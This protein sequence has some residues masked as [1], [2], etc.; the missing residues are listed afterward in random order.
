MIHRKLHP[1]TESGQSTVDYAGVGL[2][3][4]AIVAIVASSIAGTSTDIGHMIMC[5]VGSVVS[6]VG[7]GEPLSCETSDQAQAPAEH[8]QDPMAP[9]SCQASSS[10][11]SSSSYIKLGFIKLGDSFSLVQQK[12]NYIDPATGEIKT[13]YSVVATDGTDIGA[14]GG[15]GTK[16]EINGSGLGA[17]L[18]GDAGF[19]V[20]SGDTWEFDSEEEM[21]TFID[22]YS[23]YRIQQQN[24]SRK[25]GLDYAFYLRSIDNANPPPRS[26]DKTSVG[27]GFTGK[28]NVTAGAR[29]GEDTD[30]DRSFNPNIGVHADVS[31]EDSH[32]R[33]TDHR[34]GHEGEYTDTTTYSGSIGGGGD[35][36]FKGYSRTGTYEGAM[37]TTHDKDDNITS[38]S[39]TQKTSSEE[40]TTGTN[41][42]ANG[43][44]G[45][46]GSGNASDADKQTNITTTTLPVT[47]ANR[48]T[49]EQWLTQ[50]YDVDQDT[51]EG[52]L[53]LPPNVLHPDSPVPDDPMQQLL[54]DEATSSTSTYDV[55]GD[56]LS[57]SGD[58]AAG[59]KIGAGVTMSMEDATLV[60]QTYLG[61]HPTEGEARPSKEADLCTEQ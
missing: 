53:I 23:T 30:T 29:F 27:G 28:G 31:G 25:T 52:T 4:V 48:A 57:I 41:G 61:D 47:D 56:G 14:T 49:V 18:S 2:I 33:Q 21:Q 5:K 15:F 50:A 26:A 8:E 32:T 17:D 46:T 20:K 19:K 9:T 60:Q 43:G 34:E 38:I 58:V 11:V 1:F 35:V 51:G 13:R 55:S 12:E 10:T 6:Q 42:P 3:I 24:L 44:G 40:K 59:L 54:Y 7:G 39:F 16:G 36:T 37:S 45:V 22:D